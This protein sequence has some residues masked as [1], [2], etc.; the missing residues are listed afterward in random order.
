M[1]LYL[2]KDAANV[3]PL[4]HITSGER[5][6]AELK[7]TSVLSDTI[8]TSSAPIMTASVFHIT[9]I[10]STGGVDYTLGV[11]V[12]V[13]SKM[14][15]KPNR[16]LYNLVVNGMV[17]TVMQWANTPN[18]YLYWY[19]STNSVYSNDPFIEATRIKIGSPVSVTSAAIV[20]YNLDIFGNYYRDITQGTEITVNNTGITFGTVA[21]KD[22]GFIANKIVNTVDYN[23]L[24][25]NRQTR[26]ILGSTARGSNSFEIT[27][28]PLSIKTGGYEILNSTSIFNTCVIGQTLTATYDTGNIIFY[29]GQTV[30]RKIFDLPSGT[31]EFL[32]TLYFTTTKGV[33]LTFLANNE[34]FTTQFAYNIVGGSVF[35]I[36]V[37]CYGNAVYIRSSATGSSSNTLTFLGFR[38][39]LMKLSEV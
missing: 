25:F 18:G 23:F 24:D 14:F 3:N 16:L 20:V 4:L 11:P 5:S 39:Y 7:N 15:S 28:Q 26:Q 10:I 32:F 12:G 1:S 36:Y 19:G 13:L 34:S 6:E 8:F 37:K 35:S 38:A 17:H 27:T 31:S 30:D 9:S 22:I 29:G 2:G 21:L 33:E